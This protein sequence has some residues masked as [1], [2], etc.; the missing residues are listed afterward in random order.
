[1]R[2]VARF[3][4][5]QEISRRKPVLKNR[6]AVEIE[7]AIV[8]LAIEQP[9]R[10]IKLKPGCSGLFIFYSPMRS[11]CINRERTFPMVAD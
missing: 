3:L 1:L 11:V 7:E 2:D 5:L 9:G 4:A 10:T 8:A 6:I